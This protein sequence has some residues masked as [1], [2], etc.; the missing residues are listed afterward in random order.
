NAPFGAILKIKRTLTGLR[1][2]KRIHDCKT[3]HILVVVAGDGRDGVE[4]VVVAAVV[5]DVRRGG[6]ER[7]KVVCRLLAGVGVAGNL[8]GKYGGA[9][10]VEVGGDVCEV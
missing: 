4:G 9:E 6:V 1:T 8:A 10:N 2:A 3:K 5:D 7:E